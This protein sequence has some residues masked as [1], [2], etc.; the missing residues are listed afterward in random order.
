MNLRLIKQMK[1]L[2]LAYM[3]YKQ[4]LEMMGNIYKVNLKI[5][6]LEHLEKVQIDHQ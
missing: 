5:V 2:D 1:Y 6:E 4:E 3:I